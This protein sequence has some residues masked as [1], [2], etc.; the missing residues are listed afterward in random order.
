[1][2]IK[3][4]KDMKKKMKLFF[5]AGTIAAFGFTFASLDIGQVKTKENIVDNFIE[6]LFFKNLYIESDCEGRFPDTTV[7]FSYTNSWGNQS[8]NYLFSQCCQSPAFIYYD[9][10]G[11]IDSSAEWSKDYYNDEYYTEGFKN[12]F[13]K[14]FG[15]DILKEQ[16][17][18]KSVDYYRR[19]NTLN[20]FNADAIQSVFDS[21]YCKPTKKF[22]GFSY[23]KIY[24][25]TLKKFCQESAE[26]IIEILKD[27]TQFEKLAVNYKEAAAENSQFVG[28][29]YTY[30][31]TKKIFGEYY[32][33]KYPCT[34]ASY[35]LGTMMR[36]QLDGTLPVLL[37]CF[38][39]ILED[40]DPVY[41]KEMKDK[42]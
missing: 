33:Q 1:M 32:Y 41:Y 39:K 38:K 42:F 12:T 5:M 9:L 26:V 16:I 36:R 18:F 6:D 3:K 30:Q 21:L 24:D 15:K 40:Y 29:S 25:L 19:A 34:G 31:A 13:K 22:K 11:A 23:Q 20:V 8:K 7:N 4:T 35:I 28:T 2:D 27:K 37:K 10:Y 17:K 14:Y